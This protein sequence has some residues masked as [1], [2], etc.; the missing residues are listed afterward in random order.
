M[1]NAAAPPRLALWLLDRLSG[2]GDDY[3]AA[4]DYEE[5]YRAVVAELG[6]RRARREIWKQVVAAFPGHVKNTL[7][8]SNVMI[9]NYFRIAVRNLWKYKGY[10]FINIAGLSAGMA[11]CLLIFL[12]VSQE[13]SYDKYH[14]GRERI[15]RVAEEIKSKTN[16]R[17]F[18]AAGFPVGPAVKA[19]YPEVE[20]SARAF[21]RVNR[22]IE[23][24][25]RKFYEP[26]VFFIDE[27][28]FKILALPL[29]EGDP[30]TV[31]SRPDTAVLTRDMA[32]KY[33]GGEPAVG[34][35][36]KYDGQKLLEITGVLE[37]TPSAT[38]FR[39]DWLVSL[40]TLR[41]VMSREFENWYGTMAYTYVKL[42]PGAAAGEFGRRI[43]GLAERHVGDR[44]KAAGQEY[45]YFLQPVTD[46][47]LRSKLLYEIEPAGN[48]NALSLLSAAAVF[49]LAIAGMNFVSLATARSTRR[50]REVGLRKV[51]GAGH[52]QLVAQLLGESVFLSALA[53]LG[54]VLLT[55]L[56]LGFFNQLAGTS[57]SFPDLLRPRNII[58][59]AGVWL[60]A[61]FGAGIYPALLLAAFK[62]ATTLRGSF[63]AGRLGVLTRKI[64]VVGQFF[65]AALLIVGTLVI[66]RQIRFMKDQDLGFSKEQK[67]ILPVQGAPQGLGQRSEIVKASFLGIPGVRGA[68]ASLTVPGRTPWNFN[69]SLGERGAGS[70]WA[71]Y[72][73]YIDPDF[74][75][76]YG[77]Q[78]A[79]GRAF[80]SDMSADM[81]R[82][83]DQVPVFMINEAAVRAFG[84]AAGED[85][86]GRQIT[87]GH[88]GRT[89]IIIGVVKDFHFFGLQQ[90]VGPLVMEWF[91]STFGCISLN[92]RTEG[93]SET[94]AA[95]EKK[96]KELFPSLPLDSF[97]LD[98]DFNKQYRADERLWGITRAFTALGIMIS[99]LGLFGLAAYLAEQRTKEIGI[100]RVLGASASGIVA[101]FL[102]DF[103]KMV[104]LANILAIPVAWLAMNQWLRDYAY[105]TQLTPWVFVLAAGLSLAVAMLTVGYQSIRAA[106]ANPA[107]SLRNE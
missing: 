44:L 75:P 31:L 83:Y 90:K 13:L 95:V 88:G 64:L 33:F 16:T 55:G 80:Q 52:R 39:Y 66:V 101:R 79:A 6:I 46:I 70:N 23:Y 61:G 53:V 47:H 57:F 54:A 45:R 41:D 9:K 8:W 98:E 84:F 26:R 71:M 19:E 50:A 102:G 92:V 43:S 22:L 97:F 76:L 38:H 99:C 34:K 51:V 12:Y 3:G 67:L 59:I 1:K 65:I 27:D 105:H 35:T 94:L 5:Y 28:L 82:D 60:L 10:S 11:C 40:E 106:L 17:V 14:P 58:F 24:G 15:F 20:A 93:L 48:A 78:L 21:L 69:V 77:I 68:A 36:V 18:A 96:W 103:I 2:W 63:K 56:V 87:T 85:A 86:L 107:D 72:H 100:R 49:I 25:E 29:V 89:G 104:I 91:P 30:R 74:I 42:R 32:R 37:N 73:L 4:G 81:T 62:P 7:I